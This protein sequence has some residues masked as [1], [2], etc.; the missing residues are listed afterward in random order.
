[1]ILRVW[2]EDGSEEPL[3]VDVRETFDVARGL[4]RTLTFTDIDLV[5]AS[6]R[7]FLE[8]GGADGPA[9]LDGAG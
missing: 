1:M 9:A 7:T 3:R 6:V 8:S 4:G 5:L 2:S